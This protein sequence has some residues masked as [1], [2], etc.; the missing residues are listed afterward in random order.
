MPPDDLKQCPF[1][2]SDDLTI[3]L[4]PITGR[5]YVSCERCGAEGPKET[6]ETRAVSKWNT[7]LRPK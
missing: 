5:E 3:E 1:C 6:S 2:R 4:Q 7:R